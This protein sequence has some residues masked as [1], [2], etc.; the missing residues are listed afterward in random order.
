MEFRSFDIW[1]ERRKME[2]NRFDDIYSCG[3]DKKELLKCLIIFACCMTVFNIG[4]GLLATFLYR[5][6]PEL[7]FVIGL[8]EFGIIFG[9]I[10]DYCTTY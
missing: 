6:Y 5:F 2:G 3:G 1:E 9:C 4:Y 7:W 10:Y 8:V